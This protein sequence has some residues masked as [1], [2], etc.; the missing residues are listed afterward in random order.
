MRLHRRWF[1]ALPA[2]SLDSQYNI[3]ASATVSVRAHQDRAG[4]KMNRVICVRDRTEKKNEKRTSRLVKSRSHR[5][6]LKESICMC[7]H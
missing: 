6:M 3:F 7:A 1:R 2:G 4:A 5:S